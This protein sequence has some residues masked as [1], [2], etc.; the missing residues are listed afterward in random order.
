MPQ[1][2]SAVG[3]HSAGMTQRPND[4][5][6]QSESASLAQANGVH[7]GE[8][9]ARPL[10]IVF[11]I[12][13]CAGQTVHH[14][15]SSHVPPERYLRVRKRRGPGRI[16]LTLYRID[17][18]PDP[19]TLDVIGGHWVGRSIERSFDDRRI[20]RSILLRDPVSQFLSHYNYRMMRYLSQ[21][22]R[23]YSIDTAYRAR[24]RNFITNFILRTFAE[25]PWPRL[26]TM[27]TAEK[28]AEANTF[29]SDFD[30]V[31]D[32]TRCDEL[33][34]FLASDLGTPAEAELR[35]TSQ[36]W[37]ERV[38]WTLLGVSDLSPGLLDR[39][40][41]D[42]MLDQK[43][44]ETW[45]D[46]HKGPSQPGSH[47]LRRNAAAK[48]ASTQASRLLN[49]VKRRVRRGWSGSGASADSSA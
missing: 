49:Q 41:Q 2:D 33:I 28:Y 6:L 8:S 32:H 4:T 25:M 7:L 39:I 20:V 19:Q 9:T 38:D 3:H 12:P 23:P 22:L 35:N 17:D 1:P 14:H 26:A 11:H 37:R 40:K 36:Q 13:R 42:N 21:G 10:H 15:L 5:Q 29:L 31:G 44:W 24:R 46:A 48:R 27:S 43:L 30:F 34:G 16:F 18:M 47:D 45:K